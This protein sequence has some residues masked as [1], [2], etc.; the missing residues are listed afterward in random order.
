ML[1]TEYGKPL[2]AFSS[3]LGIKSD[4]PNGAVHVRWIRH[5]MLRFHND[6]KYSLLLSVHGPHYTERHNNSWLWSAKRT[7]QRIKHLSSLAVTKPTMTKN[8]PSSKECVSKGCTYL[9]SW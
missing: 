6:D 5:D 4:S 1:I 2:F 7:E 3:D 9:A 8:R